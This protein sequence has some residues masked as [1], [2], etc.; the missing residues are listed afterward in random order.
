MFDLSVNT[1]KTII[2]RFKKFQSLDKQPRGHRPKKL[3]QEQQDQ[4]KE[5]VNEDCQRTLE[6]LA[7]LIEEK[8]G[9][10]LAISTVFGYLENLH[11]TVKRT[12]IIPE[13]RN[14]QATIDLRYKYASEFLRMDRDRKKIFFLD[15]CSVSVS[16]RS[17]YG[18][19]ARGTRANVKVK[20]IRGKSYS[21]CAAI[22]CE[23]LSFYQVQD[24]AYNIIDFVDYLRQFLDL[25]DE[26]EIHHAYLVMDNVRFH[27]SVD[28]VELVESR[29]HVLKFLPP[30]SPFLNPI[31]NMFNQLK[32]YIKRLKPDTADKV[33]EAVEHASQCITAE[34]CANYYDNMLEYLPACMQKIPIE[35]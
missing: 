14:C 24:Q 31:E 4:L 18:R 16:T 35:N 10:K 1:I 32:F 28:V 26:L 25:L 23:C 15:E 8:Y 5:W 19:S 9:I 17:N 12:S 22:N 13:R 29:G 2:F 21:V 30:Y 27:H 20:A 6:D 33:Y 7:T 34:D 11:Y 3:N